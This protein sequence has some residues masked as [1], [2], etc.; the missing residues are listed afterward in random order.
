MLGLKQNV[1]GRYTALN[2]IVESTKSKDL[3]LL[4]PKERFRVRYLFWK[5]YSIFSKEL[6]T[7]G[8][9]VKA[10][11]TGHRANLYFVGSENGSALKISV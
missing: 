5:V 8:V 9:S 4:F 2:K 7:L 1:S 3:P 10:R 6:V 11:H